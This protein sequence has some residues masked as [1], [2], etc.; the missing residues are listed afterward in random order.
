MERRGHL[1]RHGAC[2]VL[3]PVEARSTD[4]LPRA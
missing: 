1:T 3:L 4:S 2:A